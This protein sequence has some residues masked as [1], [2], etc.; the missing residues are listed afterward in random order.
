MTEELLKTIIST[1]HNNYELGKITRAYYS[2]YKEHNKNCSQEE[3]AN[4]FISNV[5]KSGK[6][7]KL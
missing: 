1:F 4:M 2:F 6:T 3:L 7:F 5:I